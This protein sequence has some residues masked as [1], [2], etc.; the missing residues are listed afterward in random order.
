MAELP[1]RVEYV[2]DTVPPMVLEIPPPAPPNTPEVEL[3][4]SVEL[5]TVSV[6]RLAIPPPPARAE[7]ALAELSLRVELVTVS[8]PELSMP[9]PS[10]PRGASTRFPLRVE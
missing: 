8:V 7:L 1:L 3:P 10:L 5:T 4:L 6:L 2:T 9:P